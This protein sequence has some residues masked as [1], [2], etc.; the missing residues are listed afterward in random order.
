MLF[1]L[2]ANSLSRFLQNVLQL[3]PQ[4]VRLQPQMIQYADNTLIICEAHL[5]TLKI[6]SHVL[7]VYTDL[8]GL[9]INRGKSTFVP[10]AIPQNLIQVIQPII[11]SPPTQLPI[12]YLG[13]PLT[14]KKPRKIDYQPML[15]AMQ[16]RIEGWTS[17]FLAYGGRITLIKVI[18]SAMPLHY[19]QAFKIQVGVIRH[20]DKT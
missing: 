6:I 17:N 4:P 20:I 9:R 11:G 12:R 2:V 14:V 16:H 10:I 1:I 3:M 19:M 5:A 7:Q 8:S 13:L 15:L 18:L